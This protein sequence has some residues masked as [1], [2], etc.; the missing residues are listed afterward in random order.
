MY[1]RNSRPIEHN[2]EYRATDVQRIQNQRETL[3]S[4][5]EFLNRKHKPIRERIEEKK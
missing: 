4:C 2:V 1:K 3:V 5:G